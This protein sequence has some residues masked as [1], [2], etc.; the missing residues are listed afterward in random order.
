MRGE[1]PDDRDPADARVIDVAPAFARRHGVALSPG[2]GGR[3]TLTARTD[4]DP[5]ALLAVRR[6]LARGVDLRFVDGA[7]QAADA[8][9]EGAAAARL[10][11]AI[12]R[13][14]LRDGASDVHVEPYATGLVV[15]TRRNGVLGEAMR[16]PP[17][18]A[19]AVI[20]H[21]KSLAGLSDDDETT[22]REGRF[23][24]AIDGGAII[25]ASTL[26][27]REGERL[28]LRLPGAKQASA[29]PRLPGLSGAPERVLREALHARSGIVLVAGPA[30]SGSMTTLRAALRHLND[31]ARNILAVE[32][33][34]ASPIEGV[35]QVIAD[36]RAGPTYAA[37]L[38]ALLRQDPDVVMVSAVGDRETAE[39]AVQAALTGHL[40]LSSMDAADAVGAISRL[41]AMRI[42]PFLLASTLCAVV[43]Q[44]LVRRL[45]QQCRA[46][47]QADKSASALLGFDP[48]TIIYRPHGCG[49]CDGTGYEGRIG[50]FEAI[51]VDDTIRRLI[52]DGGDESLIARHA[53]LN[54]PNLGSAARAL[55]RDG[56]TTAEE[57]IRVSRGGTDDRAV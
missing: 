31:G 26:P 44:R 3:L 25:E 56:Q 50:V 40:L 42:E 10:I 53:F 1:V 8:Q 22:A 13:Q 36:P 39:V 4:S 51:R 35:G 46:P 57:A 45:C 6:D 33:G 48:G 38:R 34:I 47:V 23:S 21:I 12:V 2:D 49:G 18:V 5:M 37:A 32:D 27:G 17:G 11:D 54:A 41:R 20:G 15:R 16:L 52:N 14:A 19:G 9:Q 43:A 30:G 29:G 24:L 7:G 55:V 28:A